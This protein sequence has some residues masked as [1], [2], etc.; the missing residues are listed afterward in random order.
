MST[1]MQCLQEGNVYRNASM[2]ESQGFD[3]DD[4]IQMAQGL[5]WGYKGK[6]AE[7]DIKTNLFFFFE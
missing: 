1:R 7:T 3:V 5:S 6:V 2:R 4:N